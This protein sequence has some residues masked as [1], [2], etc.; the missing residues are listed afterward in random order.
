MMCRSAHI[1]QWISAEMDWVY[2][3]KKNMLNSSG[4]MMSF[5]AAMANV[6][7]FSSDVKRTN[8]AASN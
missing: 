6:D 5:T 8:K 3:I 7:H 4:K 1:I 2:E